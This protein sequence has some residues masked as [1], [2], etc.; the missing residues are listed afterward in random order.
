MKRSIFFIITFLTI[1]CH[2]VFAQNQNYQNNG[3]DVSIKY[4]NKTVYYPESAEENP[5]YVHITIANNGCR[6]G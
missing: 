3:I 4:Y 6:W 5:I 2:S 1:F